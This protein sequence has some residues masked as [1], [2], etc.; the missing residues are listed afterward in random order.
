M[1][2]I[3]ENVREPDL[4][5]IDNQRWI[6]LIREHPNLAQ[7]EPR[8]GISPFTKRSMV[9]KPLPDVA[10][11]IIDGQKVGSM[12]WALDDSNL[13]YVFGQLQAVVPLALGIAQV[14]GG[15]FRAFTN[16][17]RRWKV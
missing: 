1:D 11:V 6:D 7:P 13:I 8:E 10:R 5:G 4:P 2:L 12:S 9:I 3:G 15:H 17:E 16:E 14:L